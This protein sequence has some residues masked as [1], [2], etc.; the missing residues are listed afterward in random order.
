VMTCRDKRL[1]RQRGMIACVEVCSHAVKRERGQLHQ[2]PLE[3]PAN[4]LLVSH[5]QDLRCTCPVGKHPANATACQ[6]S[7]R[8][9][10]FLFILTSRCGFSWLIEGEDPKRQRLDRQQ[11]EEE[12]TRNKSAVAASLICIAITFSRKLLG[13]P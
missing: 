10:I 8:E 5:L 3:P 12:V 9:P 2:D 4:F 7:T 11:P 13:Q 6:G 1:W